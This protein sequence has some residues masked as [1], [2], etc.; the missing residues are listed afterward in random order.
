MSAGLPRLALLGILCVGANARPGSTWKLARSDHFEV[1][2]DAGPDTARS[3]LTCFEQI[4]A[5]FEQ[6]TN[7]PLANRPPVRVVWFR[8]LK[9]YHPYRP[10]SP[11]DPYR[12]DTERRNYI[13][14]GPLGAGECRA[15]D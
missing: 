9:Q 1:Y 2:S 6:Q 7:L 3:A 10:R 13:V 8:S 12:L 15:A 11:P 4:R 5:F 14:T